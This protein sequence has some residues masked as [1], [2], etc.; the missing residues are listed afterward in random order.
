MK[1]YARVILNT[2]TKCLF[3]EIVHGEHWEQVRKDFWKNHSREQFRLLT[4]LEV[5]EDTHPEF[6]LND[7]REENDK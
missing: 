7:L 4:V 6:R 5:P 3:T 1:S 2:S